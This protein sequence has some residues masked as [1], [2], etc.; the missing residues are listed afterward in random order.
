MGP[1]CNVAHYPGVCIL[2]VGRVE[3]AAKRFGDRFLRRLFTQDEL[4]YCMAGAARYPRLACRL[5]AKFAVRSALRGAGL[6]PHAPKAL[7]VGRDA[8]GKPF[9][10]LREA[11]EKRTGRRVRCVAT[12]S[13]S[14]SRSMAAASVVVTC[15]RER[16]A[17]GKL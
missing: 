16:R 7:G 9:I 10:V 2:E 8:W 3:T 11:K 15:R 5:A 12:L 14:H 17:R 4:R 6:A 13:L 1:R